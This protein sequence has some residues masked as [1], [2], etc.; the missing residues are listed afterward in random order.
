MRSILVWTGALGLLACG[1]HRLE[2]P[3]IDGRNATIGCYHLSFGPWSQGSSLSDSA[4]ASLSL[5]LSVHLHA[6]GETTPRVAVLGQQSATIGGR[7]RVYG[8]DSLVVRWDDDAL[9]LRFRPHSDSLAGIATLGFS[10][11]HGVT[12]P[13]ASVLAW[14][15]PCH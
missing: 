8:T 15:A 3:I 6:T 13:S 1:T 2:Q 5:P 10:E 11:A 4:L 12:L 9:T 7:W 14:R